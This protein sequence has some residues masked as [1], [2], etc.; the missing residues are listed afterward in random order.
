[1]HAVLITGLLRCVDD[2]FISF[3]R[4]FPSDA[5]FFVVTETQYAKEAALLEQNFNAEVVFIND[6][7]RHDMTAKFYHSHFPKSQSQWLKY[8]IALEHVLRYERINRV[9]FC[10]LHKLRTDINGVSSFESFFEAKDGASKD[11][12]SGDY[13]LISHDFCI[14]CSARLTGV[15]LGF[16]AYSTFFRYDKLFF[17]SELFT[18]NREVLESSD[19]TSAHVKV[20]PTGIITDNSSAEKWTEMSHQRFKTFVE[21]ACSFQETL[22]G[23]ERT[24]AVDMAWA[25]SSK[26]R[27]WKQ[28]YRRDGM[29]G[30]WLKY[31]NRCGIRTRRYNTPTGLRLA[32]FAATPFTMALLGQFDAQNYGLLQDPIDWI[33]EFNAFRSCGGNIQKLAQALAETCLSNRRSMQDVEFNALLSAVFLIIDD[34]PRVY[35]DK[36]SRL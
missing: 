33:G 8:H 20:Y 26:V 18:L 31:L 27:T 3:L 9:H 11:I 2:Y 30:I 23:E 14:S 15:L 35:L 10:F 13:V 5:R 7:E 22:E 12:V 25:K 16:L 1:M 34:V 36:L 17:E 6:P 24:T 21:A 28:Q 4:T 32:R 29:F 19:G